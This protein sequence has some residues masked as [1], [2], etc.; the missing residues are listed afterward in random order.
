MQQFCHRVTGEEVLDGQLRLSWE[1]YLD[2]YLHRH[3]AEAWQPIIVPVVEGLSHD[4]LPTSSAS[5]IRVYQVLNQISQFLGGAED[6]RCTLHSLEQDLRRRKLIKVCGNSAS[7]ELAIQFIFQVTG[8]L[9][10]FWDPALDAST[11]TLSLAQRNEGLTTRRRITMHSPAIT[12]TTI[13]ISEAKH[14]LS[15]LLS[16]FGTVLPEPKVVVR[17]AFRGGPEAGPDDLSATYLTLHNLQQDLKIT[18]RWTNT[19]NQ[20]LE[21]DQ[22]NNILYIFRYPSICSLMAQ[23]G[24]DT[25]F[26][27]TYKEW[28]QEQER[29]TSGAE[30]LISPEARRVRRGI[31]IEDYFVEVLLSYD[32]IFGRCPKS[33]ASAK[34]L[35]SKSAEEWKSAGQYDPLLETLCTKGRDCAEVAQLLK[36][37]QAGKPR[38][39]ISVDEYPF[40]GERLAIL[41][42]RSSRQAPHNWKRLW[43]D[44]RNLPAWMALW[45]VIVFG[46]GTLLLQT[47]QLILQGFQTW[48]R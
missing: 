18:L 40:L 48:P 3:I 6:A 39:S 1:W 22:P 46:G 33:R 42:A 7:R 25:L 45:A 29:W 8:W 28:I 38:D 27:R 9:A 34:A 16:R 15:L 19:L 14:T 2:Q 36:E 31:K 35:L 11:T 43:N 24:H 32:L 17:E 12:S 26:S 47:I 13:G 23:K 5:K 21:F 41:H 37:L 30:K 4:S 10:A 20:H 44:T